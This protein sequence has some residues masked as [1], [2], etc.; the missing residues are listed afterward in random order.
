VKVEVTQG[1]LRAAI[2]YPCLVR[3]KR[4][5]AVIV[6]KVDGARGYPLRD[7]GFGQMEGGYTASLSD[8]E[9]FA[10]TLKFTP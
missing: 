3:L 5:P 4:D 1:G 9:P 7:E 6:L 10:G 8:W 2:T